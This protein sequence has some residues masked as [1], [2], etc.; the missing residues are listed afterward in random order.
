MFLMTIRCVLQDDDM[1]LVCRYGSEQSK[2]KIKT[3]SQQVIKTSRLKMVDDRNGQVYIL[4]KVFPQPTVRNALWT[5]ESRDGVKR[6]MRSG[7]QKD[8][9]SA[10]VI[11][12]EDE[13]T[14]KFLLNIASPKEEI[15]ATKVRLAISTGQKMS[16][17]QFDMQLAV[18]SSIASNRWS[19]KRASEND[20][21]SYYR[22]SS[23]ETQQQLLM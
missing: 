18:S 1:D 9:L 12:G 15:I 21:F 16:E 17:T 2:L 5:V 20:N 13:H 7:E 22:Q 4:A 8:N 23:Q 14:Y 3:F 6:M 11:E 19:V 10:E